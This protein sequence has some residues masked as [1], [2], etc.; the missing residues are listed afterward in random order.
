ML[1]DQL[2]IPGIGFLPPGTVPGQGQHGQLVRSAVALPS[3]RGFQISEDESPRP[4]DRAY[5]GFNYFDDINRS[6]NDRLGINI[7]EIRVYRETFGLEKTF[8]DG[9]VSIGLRLPL[10]TLSAETPIAGL[11]G[12][13]TDLGD[14]T[15]ILKGVLLEDRRSGDVLSGGL[16]ITTP[17]GPRAFA[18]SEVISTFH[19]T[20]L[21]PY[22]GY[23]YNMDSW[24]VH[25]FSSIAVPTDSNDVTLLFNDI[26]IGYY[27]Y[28]DRSC[29]SMISAIIPTFEVHVNTPLN[30]RG[31]LNFNDPAGTPDWVDLTAGTTIEFHKRATLALGFVTPVTGPKPYEFEVLCQLNIRLGCARQ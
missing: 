25:G 16:A 22:V 9:N 14:L 21:Q 5:F 28:R 15:V 30:H 17:N 31:A 29:G 20:I 1:G 7:H 19:D 12:S 24:F 18:G 26:G 8:L 23:I 4:L 11:G 10:N 27:L 6:I 3:V 13:S 2:G